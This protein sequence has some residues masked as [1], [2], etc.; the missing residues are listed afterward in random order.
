M[1]TP[2]VKLVEVTKR[3]SGVL[4]LDRVNLTLNAGE[5]LGL[6]GENG[7]GKSTLMKI[8]SGVY[9]SGEFDGRVEVD[10]L[11]AAFR[12]PADAEESGI[13]I[14]HQELSAFPELTVAENLFVGHWP[15]KSSVFGRRIEWTK[16]EETAQIWLD[17]VGATAKPSDR[18]GD[19]SLG[20]QQLVEI[21]KA[22]LRD[23]RVFIFDE[24]TSSLTP[25]ETENLK[26]LIRELKGRKCAL[27][28][29]SHKM[30]EIFELC[31]RLVVLRD[32]KNVYE[33]PTTAITPEKLVEPMV[34]RTIQDIYPKPPERA[35][36][37]TLLEVKDYSAQFTWSKIPLG[38]YNYTL[39]AGEIIGFGG[40]LGCGRTEVLKSLF[41][42]KGLIRKSGEVLLHGKPVK[43]NTPREALLKGFSFVSEDRKGESILP[44]RSLTENAGL[45]RLMITPTKWRLDHQ[46]EATR[47]QAGLRELN[48]KFAD[49][50]QHIT[51][52]SGGN[53]QKVIISRALETGADIIL[54]DEPTRGID[55]S[56]KAE[57][58]EIIFKLA[59]QGKGILLVSSD[60]PELMALS[61]RII[62]VNNG[63]PSQIVD[64]KDFNQVKLMKLVI[65]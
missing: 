18:M 40:L 62:M 10:G 49:L 21:A 17:R 31:D 22:L 32:G 65:G 37:K 41:G 57:I 33:S 9:G 24:P 43:P 5:V 11:L 30:E 58:Y 35:L 47:A 38:P 39:H 2:V 13:A 14:I 44:Q 56:A 6:V 27:V 45:S 28:Y 63:R 34:G 52:L 53:Q 54:L 4:A 12:R 50:S 25:K 48:T 55:V 46:D 3:F 36:D 20:Q 29:I 8:L 19:L 59:K 42:F 16:I 64:R 15:S 26:K 1:S 51:Q 60:L 23:G 61:D 7:A